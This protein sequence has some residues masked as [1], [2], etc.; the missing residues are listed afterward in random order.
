M[1]SIVLCGRKRATWISLGNLL[2]FSHFPNI[3]SAVAAMMMMVIWTILG[4]LGQCPTKR[5][6]VKVAVFGKNWA[7]GPQPCCF[8]QPIYG[9]PP[10][11]A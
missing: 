1:V 10:G 3:G 2:C 7:S 4:K 11:V 9:K 5:A 6:N 8:G